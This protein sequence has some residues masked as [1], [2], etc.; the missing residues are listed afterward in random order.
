[1]TLRAYLDTLRGKK[2]AVLGVGV[3]NRPLLRLLSGIDATVTAYDR[4]DRAALG[5]RRR[6]WKSAV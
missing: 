1:M 3:S 6:N 2:V 4:R 5:E